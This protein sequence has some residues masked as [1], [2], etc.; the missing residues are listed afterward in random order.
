MPNPS[1]A[2]VTI[3]EMRF[4]ALSTHVGISIAHDDRGMP[5][6]GSV[7]CSMSVTVDIHDTGNLPFGTLQQLFESP[8]RSSR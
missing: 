2:T 1:H 4:D 3:D 8:V 7:V 6:M 5:L